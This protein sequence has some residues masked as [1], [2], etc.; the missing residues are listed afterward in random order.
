M[1]E[2]NSLKR[3]KRKAFR[4][5]NC[6][7]SFSSH[8]RKLMKKLNSKRML[9]PS[10]IQNNVK[11]RKGAINKKIDELT[12]ETMALKQLQGKTAIMISWDPND[13]NKR[14][15][16]EIESTVNFVSESLHMIERCEG[17][18]I[19]H[20]ISTFTNLNSLPMS[21]RC[22]FLNNNMIG[23]RII[24]QYFFLCL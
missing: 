17:K 1:W 10:D 5:K 16:I 7:K 6:G 20:F 13:T 15:K 23:R 18:D 3:K 2:V 14:R 21:T 19:N 4:Y 12:I 9:A 22:V 8:G 24:K 11:D